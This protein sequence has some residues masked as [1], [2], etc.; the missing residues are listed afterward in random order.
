MGTALFSAFSI[1]TVIL[2]IVGF[3]LVIIEMIVP[4]FG[5][6][7]IIGAICLIAAV[8][9]T[10]TSFLEALIM[11]LSILAVLGIML[12]VVLRS[13]TKGKLF[14]P[15]ILTEEQRKEKGYIS[16]SNL[17]YLLGKSGVAITDLRPSGSADFDGVKF[18]VVADGEYISKGTAVR[19]FKVQGSKLCVKRIK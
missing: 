1:L 12:A 17:E 6:P 19:I 5:L 2:L 11:I 8:F 14:N 9:I 4:G 10:S 13:F 3:A 18:D 16:Y 15:L 7:G